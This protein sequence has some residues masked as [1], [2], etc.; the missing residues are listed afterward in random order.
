M[1]NITLN[2]KNKLHAYGSGIL[3]SNSDML[4]KVEHKRLEV[5][6]EKYIQERKSILK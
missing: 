1:K 5:F 6:C 3:F 2:F 4:S